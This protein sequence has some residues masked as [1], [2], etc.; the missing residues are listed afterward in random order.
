MEVIAGV[1]SAIT[2]VQ[3]TE[4]IGN[5]CGSYI[6]GVRHAQKDI[7]RLQSKVSALNEVM[8]RLNHASLPNINP[9]TVQKCC[10][11]V[12]SIRER[13][14]PKET[15]ATRKRWALRA[16]A[17]KWPFT[18][19]EVEEQV[20][21]MEQ[22]LSLFS[23]TLSQNI[24]E[25]A[26]DAE[27]EQLLE[28]LA[29]AGDAPF[30]SYE[31]DHRHRPCLENTRVDVLQQ[32]MDWTTNIPEQ[33]IFWLRGLAG[34]GKSTIA[35]TVGYQLKAKPCHIASYFFK[36]GHSDL[37]EVRK[38][39]PTIVR[40]LS[41]RPSSYRRLVSEAVKKEPGLGQSANLREQYEKLLV[42]PLRKIRPSQEPFFIIMDALDECDE[43]RDLRM[44]LRL[45]ARTEDIPQLGLKIFVTSRP[46]LPIRNGFKEIPRI[47]HCYLALQ[48]VPR[49]VVDGDIRAFLRH[50]LNEIQHEFHL[51]ADW[52]AYEDLDTLARKAGGLFIFAATAVRYIRGSPLALPEERLK[53]VCNTVATNTLMTEELD[54]MYTIVLKKSVPGKYTAKEE[55]IARVRFRHIVGSIVLLL[56]P[57]SIAQ[58]FSL[59]SGSHVKSQKELEVVLQALNAV[60]DVP[61]DGARGSIQ[62]LHLSF[63]DFLLDPKRCPDRRFLVDEQQAHQDLAL[64]CVRLLSG[65]LSR[66]LCQLPSLGTLRSEIDPTIVGDILSQAV[67]YACR[68]LVDHAQRGSMVVDDHGC[69]HAFLQKHFLHWVWCMSLLGRISQA[70]ASMTNLTAMTDVR[71]C[72][73]AWP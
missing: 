26:V 2:I 11:D 51:P 6:R 52:P 30:N 54:E 16:R 10:D 61:E 55:E 21:A 39:I 71:E 9:T 19:K 37:A 53:D 57:L 24:H 8:T 49:S 38:L 66:E 15:Q 4:E 72:D 34:T 67:E 36:R 14:K 62:P 41:E 44:L 45:L 68:H 47:F 69:I 58:L 25:K 1:A 70:I 48:N 73:L 23:L 13:L 20:K 42:E 12:C 32:I 31:N 43:P 22:Y 18:S 7:E 59:V 3:V 28:K 33:C 17:L 46:E 64:S 35:T 27:Q 56:D 40:Q 60:I 63:R 50:E 5:L 65:S 29:Y